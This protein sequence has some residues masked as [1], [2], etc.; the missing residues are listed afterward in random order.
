MQVYDRLNEELI[1]F[2]KYAS[3]RDSAYD[4]FDMDN[5]IPRILQIDYTI[6]TSKI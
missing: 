3:S 5:L 1:R 6:N 4:S 2:V